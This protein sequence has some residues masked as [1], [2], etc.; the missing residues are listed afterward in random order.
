VQA[1][2]MLC[3]PPPLRAGDLV[4]VIAPAGAVDAAAL[5]AGIAALEAA[6]L[7]VRLGAHALHRTGYLAGSDVERA[8]D[9]M[10]MLRDPDVRAVIAARGGYGAGRLLSLIEPASVRAACKIFVGHSDVTFL[11]TAFVQEA[12]VVAFHGPMVTG[13]PQRPRALESL[14]GLLGGDRA[15]WTL[16]A[17]E[18]VRPGIGEGVLTGGC[19]A[20]VTAMLGTPHAIDVRG[21]LLFLEDVNERPF[22]IDRM[23]TQLRQA[24]AF[25]E[26]AGVI[27]GEMADC[28]GPGEDAV[29][30]RDVVAEAFAVAPFPVAF[31]LPSG[32]GVG[33]LTV[34]LGV[35]ARLD[36]ATLTLLESPLAE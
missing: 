31:G 19:L 23:L 35:R 6:G 8:A 24:G 32:H 27:F 7:H 16:T 20:I 11:L 2:R 17:P 4:G 29:T 28:Y 34:P 26:V 5:E 22:R 1:D 9:L 30:V 13:L 36:G 10:A 14:L 3:K 12:G 21:R 33:T 15:E 25:D 18:A